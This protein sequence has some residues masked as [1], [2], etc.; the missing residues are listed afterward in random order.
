M[1]IVMRIIQQYDPAHE[2]EFMALE[3]KFALLEKERPNFPKGLRLQPVS[4]GEPNNT[5]IWQCEFPDM[6]AAR[7]ALDSFSRDEKHE[8]LFRHQV[9]Y[10]KQV[11][12][13]FYKT[14]DF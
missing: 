6:N 13:H 9:K 8:E 12:I 10:I 14:L 7:Q 4:A 1:G 3:K 2:D 11:N 5:L